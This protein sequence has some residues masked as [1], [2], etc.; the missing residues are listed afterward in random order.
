MSSESETLLSVAPNLVVICSFPGRFQ[1]V[2]TL[3]QTFPADF[4]APVVLLQYPSLSQGESALS[5]ASCQEWESCLPDATSLTVEMV[6]GEC[7]LSPRTLY[8]TPAHGSVTLRR[9]VILVE[10]EVTPD[11]HTRS[12]ALLSSAACAYQER[13][14]LVLFPATGS[15]GVAEVVAVKRAGGTVVL[16]EQNLFESLRRLGVPPAAV[17]LTADLS[18]I[19]PLLH[20]FLLT[21]EQVEVEAS[22]K[23]EIDNVLAFLCL[24]SSLIP[25]Q[26]PF[27]VLLQ[28]IGWHMMRTRQMA[29]GVY[30]RYLHEQPAEARVLVSAILS[31]RPCCF[32]EAAFFAMLKQQILPAVIEEARTR[33]W[34]LR[35]WSA[36][37]YM[38]QEPYALAM[39]LTDLLGPDLERFK[40]KIF[41]TDDHYAALAFAREGCYD[42]KMLSDLPEDYAVRFFEPSKRGYRVVRAIRELII[43]G[44]HDLERDLPFSNL[45]VLLCRHLLASFPPE[46]YNMLLSRFAFALAPRKGYLLL[47]QEG[48]V[49][50]SSSFFE[51][52]S[53]QEP[54]YRCL[55]RGEIIHCHHGQES[56]P[57]RVLPE[58]TI[59]SLLTDQL[60][61]PSSSG[62][63]LFASLSF[64]DMVVGSAPFGVVV[65]DCSYCMLSWNRAAEQMLSISLMRTGQDFFHTVRGLPYAQV[66]TSIDTIFAEGGS[67]TVSPV[68]LA[69]S[70]GGNGRILAL[71]VTLLPAEVDAILRVVLYFKDISEQTLLEQA[72]LKQAQILEELISTNT[73]LAAENAQLVNTN[74]QL[75]EASR[76]MLTA[77]EQLQERLVEEQLTTEDL[78]TVQEELQITLEEE[79]QTCEELNQQCA[80]YSKQLA[81]LRVIMNQQVRQEA[82]A[83]YNTE[84][85]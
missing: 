80:E 22:V 66:R 38:G 13:L 27:S 32:P 8:V 15:D 12:E 58:Q 52:V 50:P 35:F 69:F 11:A 48:R 36:G 51:R 41:A 7:Q 74:Q 44:T 63:P 65:V 54:L 19:G 29:L 45:N 78:M 9:G 31:P 23:E 33:D 79:E 16:P 57:A 28:Q 82:L 18:Q 71:T 42:A 67:L 84:E 62:F 46:Q 26:L 56:Q 39:V 34:T 55:H 24:H 49:H 10:E 2:L 64:S 40:V 14:V 53:P 6:W 43:F 20:S 72:H 75:R 37:C 3:L 76:A 77:Y 68:D 17:D 47:G 30:T 83:V 85:A 21:R 25:S 4:P 5:S 60:P 59:Q 73:D 81:E 70:A 1:S 61:P